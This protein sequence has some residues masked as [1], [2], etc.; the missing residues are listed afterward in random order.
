MP[1]LHQPHWMNSGWLQKQQLSRPVLIPKQNSTGFL[2]S[3][4]RLSRNPPLCHAYSHI[5]YVTQI[6]RCDNVQLN[7]STASI[8]QS[9]NQNNQDQLPVPNGRKVAVIQCSSFSLFIFYPSP[10]IR[11]KFHQFFTGFRLGYK[12]SQSEFCNQKMSLVRGA[13]SLSIPTAPYAGWWTFSCPDS[14]DNYST[15]FLYLSLVRTGQHASPGQWA[16]QPFLFMLGC[17]VQPHIFAR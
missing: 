6:R 15:I 1:D 4:G 2:N 10:G 11:D 3:G 16:G 7:W 8:Y 12:T 14:T 13:L 17:T 5:S 9:N